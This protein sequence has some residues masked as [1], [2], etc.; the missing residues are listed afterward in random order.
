V[1]TMRRGLFIS[2]EGLDGCGKSTQAQLIKQYYESQCVPVEVLREPGATEIG[3]SIRS[4]ILSNSH[5]EMSDITEVLLYAAAR[6]QLVHQCIRPMLAQRKVVICDRFLDSTLAYQGY[7]RR[8]GTSI[9]HQLNEPGLEGLMPDITFWLD[10]HPETA[11]IRRNVRLGV[12]DRME[13][14][15]IGFMQRVAE[16]YHALAKQ[17]PQRIVRIDAEQEVDQIC[18]QIVGKLETM[19]VVVEA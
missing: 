9:V 16:G 3:E 17:Y 11:M 5:Q 14:T 1:S 18:L 19:D 8:L 10:V 13:A 6:T 12:E 4:V 2:L 7:A 15:G